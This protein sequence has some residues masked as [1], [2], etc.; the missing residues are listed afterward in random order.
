M[1]L[2]EGIDTENDRMVCKLNK[3]LC[4]SKQAA[5]CWNKQFHEFL[6]RFNFQQSSANHCVY[7][8]QFEG[9]KVYLALYV[10]DELIN[11]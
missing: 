10:D 4:G 8:G 1:Q 3:V 5:R 11:S 6:Q 7:L 2:P 9:E